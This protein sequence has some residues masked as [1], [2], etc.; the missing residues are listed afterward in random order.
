MEFN[1]T[2]IT[3]LLDGMGYALG[4]NFGSENKVIDNIFFS[5]LKEKPYIQVEGHMDG[6]DGYRRRV[7]IEIQKEKVDLHEQADE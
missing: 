4:N 5:P 6:K 7:N 2:D 1:K 3:R